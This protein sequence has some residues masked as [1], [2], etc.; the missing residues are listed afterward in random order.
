MCIKYT[1]QNYYLISS[2]ILKPQNMDGEIS[3]FDYFIY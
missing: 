1:Y 2:I 3:F